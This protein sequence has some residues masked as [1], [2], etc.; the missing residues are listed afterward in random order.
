MFLRK[1]GDSQVSVDDA[2]KIF[3]LMLEIIY[4]G[5]HCSYNILDKFEQDLNKISNKFAREIKQM[6]FQIKIEVSNIKKYLF[7][8]VNNSLAAILFVIQF[9][10]TWNHQKNKFPIKRILRSLFYL[11]KHL[12]QERVSHHLERIWYKHL[13]IIL[14]A[15]SSRKKYFIAWL[16]L[17]IEV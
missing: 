5:C 4:Y 3:I 12:L 16:H 9:K 17:Q 6:L 10:V 7:F 1:R 2:W 11:Q 14:M 13:K 15:S 8:K